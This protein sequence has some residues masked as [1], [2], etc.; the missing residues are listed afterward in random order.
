MSAACRNPVLSDSESHFSATMQHAITNFLPWRKA[1]LHIKRKKVIMDLFL[2]FKILYQV[3]RFQISLIFPNHYRVSCILLS[4]VID[5]LYCSICHLYGRI[6]YL[7]HD[8]LCSLKS[9]MTTYYC[10]LIILAIVCI[11]ALFL[12]YTILPML[13]NEFK[14]IRRESRFLKAFVKYVV[15]FCI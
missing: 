3:L 5:I 1:V 13:D 11:V 14:W 4:F 6:I 2:G 12:N 8:F 7:L 10:G 9:F 15:N